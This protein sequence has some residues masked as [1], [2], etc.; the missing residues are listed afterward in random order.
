[1][2][3]TFEG[4]W[5]DLRHRL[6]VGTEMKGWSRDKEDTGLRFKIVD[7]GADSIT[8]VSSPMPDKPKPTER[9]I[10]RTDFARVYSSWKGYCGY[11]ITRADMTKLSQ[12]TSYIFSILRWRETSESVSS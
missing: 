11:K 6:R 12:N 3:I 2:N 4:V 1:M 10:G 7:V 8:I 5:A 9:R